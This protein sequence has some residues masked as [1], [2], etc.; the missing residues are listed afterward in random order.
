V[1]T[2][3]KVRKAK[4]SCLGTGRDD[5]SLHPRPSNGGP[6]TLITHGVSAPLLLLVG[7][8]LLTRARSSILQLR[9]TNRFSS[10]R[11]R[12][13]LRAIPVTPIA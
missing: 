9:L 11:R 6:D 1:G 13:L 5:I 2:A 3:P 12:A 8:L 4:T 7:V 10:T